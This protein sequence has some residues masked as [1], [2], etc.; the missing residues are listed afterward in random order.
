MEGNEGIAKPL[1]LET[2][3]VVDDDD[4][5]RELLCAYLS[6][7]GYRVLAAADGEQMWRCLERHK[8]HLLILDLML[9]GE[10]GLSLCR[11][12]QS[13]RGPGVIMLSAKGSPLDRIIG[14][15]VGA[16]DYLGKPFEPRELLARIKA[17][18]RR[19]ERQEDALQ[20]ECQDTSL[21]FAGY[22]LDHRKRILTLPD[23]QQRSL[24][25]SDY[26]VLRDLL[27]APEQILSRGQL[28]QS[29]F[30]R[31]HL[32]DDR[33]VDMCVSRLR[34]HLKRVP[35]NAVSIL[36]IRNEGYL[37]SIQDEDR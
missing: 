18:L 17:V 11:Q 30:G 7:A 8:V 24:P 1:A 14:L 34:Q 5:I 35:G 32:P 10:D 25:R 31:D 29:V 12:L 4:E 27:A 15:E 2:L 19:A 20:P 3:L 28:T 16:D 36:T 37:L 6:D 26:R 13:L 21:E 33:S 22:R 23:G 9:P